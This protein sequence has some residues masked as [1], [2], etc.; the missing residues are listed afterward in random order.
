MAESISAGL[1]GILLFAY[2]AAVYVFV[3]ALGT[4]P[5]GERPN[6]WQPLDQQWYLNLLAFILLALTIVPVSRWLYQRVND[7]VMA[8]MFLVQATIESAAA[9][10]DGINELG[11]QFSG[12]DRADKPQ[13]RQSHSHRV[14]GKSPAHVSRDHLTRA[15]SGYSMLRTSTS[16]R[17]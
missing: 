3:I 8:E 1:L 13:R 2:I 17:G 16:W 5:F 14:M 10:G 6:D 4:L 12:D 7:L 11:R 9:I 15:P